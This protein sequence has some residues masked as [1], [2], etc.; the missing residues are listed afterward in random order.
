MSGIYRSERIIHSA[1]RS[2]DRYFANGSV[3]RNQNLSQNGYQVTT[4]YRTFGP[5]AELINDLSEPHL[6]TRTG[7]SPISWTDT[8]HPFD[9]YKK[10]FA[11]S[12]KRVSLR[13]PS[14][15]GFVG[16]YIP[17]ALAGWAEIPPMT[18]NEIAL[19]GTRLFNSAVP[20]AS[21]TNIVRTAGELV[22]D[23]LPS[24]YSRVIVQW[25]RNNS[26]LR[27]AGSDYLNVSFGWLPF[28]SDFLELL[29]TVIMSRDIVEQYVRDAGREVHRRRRMPF[30][31]VSTS[32]KV[33]ESNS[34]FREAQGLGNIDDWLAK[35]GRTSVVSTLRQEYTFTGMFMYFLH[36]QDEILD[37]A[38]YYA[39]LAEKLLG[40]QLTPSLLWELQPFSWLI[41]WNLN[42]GSYLHAA[43]NYSRD[44]LVLK[45]GY[46]QRHSVAN[47]E[48]TLSDMQLKNGRN[49]KPFS[50]HPTWCSYLT[51]R[52]ERVR[53]Q[54]FGFAL[55]PP[56]Y[57]GRQ[58]ATLAALAAS[59]HG[60]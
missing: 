23:G 6:L 53:A 38:R 37:R 18:S 49:A 14:R 17:K 10:L 8:G 15:I 33:L 4:S 43:E 52:K 31:T 2:Y 32:T 35:Y 42:I 54:P 27:N 12:N 59:R 11:S 21:A 29:R 40:L 3:A 51:M 47:N 5:E 19:N 45:Y 24:F 41:D 36:D 13:L 50:M 39:S 26:A 58:W 7:Y 60:G 44:G 25:Q 20:T 55:S 46:L 34:F 56:V 22:K 48:V 30:Q 1:T 16:S 9:T 57:D 28:I